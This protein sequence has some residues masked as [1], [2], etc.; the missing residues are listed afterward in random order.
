MEWKEWLSNIKKVS[1]P[2]CAHVCMYEHVCKGHR[3]TSEASSTFFETESLRGQGL[4]EQASEPRG[5][6][7]LQVLNPEVTSKRPRQGF[8]SFLFLNMGSG[9]S[10]QVV[11][12]VFLFTICYYIVTAQFLLGW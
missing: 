12:C 2:V 10:N 11:W 7:C 4:T 9:H 6:S 5:F 1:T 3:M 8:F